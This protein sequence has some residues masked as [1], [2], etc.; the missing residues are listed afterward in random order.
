MIGK[1][2]ITSLLSFIVCS[3]AVAREVPGEVKK[4]IPDNYTACD[5]VKGDLNRDKYG[6]AI[7]ILCRNDEFSE[8]DI[9]RPLLIFKGDAKGN[10]EFVSRN[11]NV[12]YCAKCG[13]I[14]GDPYVRTVI[15][16]GYFTVEH[17]G[18][19]A[20]RWSRLV[21]FQYN[22]KLDNWYLHRDGGESFHV[23][24]PQQKKS[25][26]KTRKDFGNV[27]FEKFDIYKD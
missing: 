24:D 4:Y 25:F 15:K 8:M 16:K 18:G 12:V 11:D 22:R 17:Y 19:S 20:W 21:T 6:D 10:L 26:M 27:P 13:G 9:K 5:F 14:F 7:V 2:A 1:I 23:N 3:N